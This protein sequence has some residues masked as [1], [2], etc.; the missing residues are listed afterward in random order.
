MKRALLG[1]ALL[2]VG[3]TALSAQTLQ[4]T[5]FHIVNWDSIYFYYTLPDGSS[6]TVELE[7]CSS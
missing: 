2:L 6:M 3:A 7:P 1:L 4:P 5:G